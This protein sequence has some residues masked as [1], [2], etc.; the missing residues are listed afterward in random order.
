MT[1]SL[2][3]KAAPLGDLDNVAVHLL[4]NACGGDHGELLVGKLAFQAPF[5]RLARDDMTVQILFF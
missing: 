2:L 5:S 4:R 3:H 1:S